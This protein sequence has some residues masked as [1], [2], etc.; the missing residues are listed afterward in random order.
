MA[1]IIHVQFGRNESAKTAQDATGFCQQSSHRKG[2]TI[3]QALTHSRDMCRHANDLTDSA[4]T[5]SRDAANLREA[6]VALREASDQFAQLP[7]RARK[8]VEAMTV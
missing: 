5:L 3:L 2:G 4:R 7:G 8:L 1:E 6:I